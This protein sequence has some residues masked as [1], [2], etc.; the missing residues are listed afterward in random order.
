MFK[1]FLLSDRLSVSAN[2]NVLIIIIGN[3][4]IRKIPYRYITNALR[5]LPQAWVL[6]PL[7]T[8]CYICTAGTA[9]S[10]GTAAALYCMLCTA[11]TATSVGTAVALYCMLC[12]AGTAT[13]VGT[14]AAL[15]CML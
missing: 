3:W 2:K 12:T 1:Q 6:P 9:T 8:V 5:V 15:Y 10:V 7:Y 11:R 13:S 14:A 4:N